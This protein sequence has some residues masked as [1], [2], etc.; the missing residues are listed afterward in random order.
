MCILWNTNAEKKLRNDVSNAEL[1]N[2]KR[3]EYL[4]CECSFVCGHVLIEIV[5]IF[6][7]RLEKFFGIYFTTPLVIVTVHG[8]LSGGSLV[9]GSV[10]PLCLL[11]TTCLLCLTLT[12]T[13][14][15]TPNSRTSEPPDK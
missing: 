13:L 15:L 10:P 2:V 8:H 3:N 14:T 5:F 6:G 7:F 11:T 12:L 1:N 9:R 4:Y